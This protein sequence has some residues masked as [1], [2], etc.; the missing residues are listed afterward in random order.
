MLRFHFYVC[1]FIFNC[2]SEN[3]GKVHSGYTRIITCPGV[4]VKKI[5]IL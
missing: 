3:V 2:N 5:Y 1:V 4:S